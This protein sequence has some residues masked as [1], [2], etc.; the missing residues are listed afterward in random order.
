MGDQKPNPGST[1]AV[2]DGCR[3]PAI[4]NHYGRGIRDDGVQFVFSSECPMHSKPVLQAGRIE[5]GVYQFG[6]GEFLAVD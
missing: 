2:Q 3:C 5:P 6:G 1:E 4:D